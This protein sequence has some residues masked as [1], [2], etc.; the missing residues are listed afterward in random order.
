MEGH[1]C[2]VISAFRSAPTKGG[3]V[4]DLLN[5]LSKTG[6]KKIDE[7]RIVKL[8]ESMWLISITIGAY[9][10]TVFRYKAAFIMPRTRQ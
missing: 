5:R 3:G 2:P 6:S 9:E 10:N 7:S 8:I 1:L 4:D